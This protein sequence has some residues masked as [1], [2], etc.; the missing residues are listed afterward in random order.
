MSADKSRRTEVFSMGLLSVGVI[1]CLVATVLFYGILPADRS[2]Q[3]V[4]SAT[5]TKSGLRT[6]DV[7]PTL[8][9]DKFMAS[10]E[11]LLQKCEEQDLQ[12]LEGCARQLANAFRDKSANMDPFLEEL[13]SLKNKFKMGWL[14]LKNDGSLE[15]HLEELLYTRLVS[16]KQVEQQLIAITGALTK[17]LDSNHNRLM[18]AMGQALASNAAEAFPDTLGA[19]TTDDF[20]VSFDHALSTVLPKTVGVQV[21]VEGISLLA[22]AFVA[23]Y[24]I[25]VM[26]GLSKV[27]TGTVVAAMAASNGTTAGLMA[28]G[29]ATSWETL[30]LS[31]LVGSALA[32]GIDY[33]SNEIATESV[34]KDMEKALRQWQ[35]ATCDKFRTGAIKGIRT[36]QQR[37]RQALRAAVLHTYTAAHA[38]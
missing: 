17:E 14:F 34:R 33:F 12:A 29:L 20:S 30:G 26:G 25:K 15:S 7:D 37:R 10:Q 6:R 38:S 31:L 28:A 3:Q 32:I 11:S 13:F 27:A 24:I 22:D 35:E 5:D 2:S 18:L 1:C 8:L 21:G 4:A 16:P 36:F 19:L 9:T 23:P